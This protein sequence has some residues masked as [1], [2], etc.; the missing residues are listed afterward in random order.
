MPILG[1]SWMDRSYVDAVAGDAE[2]VVATAEVE[3]QLGEA[4]A[5][6]HDAHRGRIFSSTRSTPR[7]TGAK[8]AAAS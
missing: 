4:R 6:G 2:H 7:N 8:V 1:A 5:Q 3:G